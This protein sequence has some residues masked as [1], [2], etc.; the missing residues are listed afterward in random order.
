MLDTNALMKLRHLDGLVT[1]LISQQQD[2]NRRRISNASRSAAANDYVI[3]EEIKEQADAVET[4]RKKIQAEIDEIQ[5]HLKSLDTT[6]EDVVVTINVTNLVDNSSVVY[7]TTSGQF[8][9]TPNPV[10]S[11]Y[12]FVTSVTPVF[13][14]LQYLDHASAPQTKTLVE[15]VNQTGISIEFIGGIAQA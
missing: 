7:N 9:Q 4:T 8:E 15:S 6:T 3:Q 2:L 12:T 5:R 14:N 1:R 11:T 13:Y 10:N